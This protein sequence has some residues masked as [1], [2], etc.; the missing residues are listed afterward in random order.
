VTQLLASLSAAPAGALA[1]AAARLLTAGVDGLHLDLADGHFVP[2]L[3]FPPALVADLRG[4]FPEAILDVHLMVEEPEAYWEEL[5]R[6]GAS[7]VTFHAEATRYPWRTVTLAHRAGLAEVGVAL[8]PMTPFEAL[9]SVR[10]RIAV[11]DLLTTE[12]DLAGEQLLPG[13]VAR[14]RRLRELL[15]GERIQVDGGVTEESAA[16]L[17]EAGAD[18]LVVGRAIT[19]ADDWHAAVER[20]R[21]ALRS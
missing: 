13:S 8:N 15:P 20:L 5:A 19:G 9:E 10:G 11:V 3:A 14:V 1:D 12:P 4:R 2:Y 16:A 18:E 6:A 7:R 21:A 17:A